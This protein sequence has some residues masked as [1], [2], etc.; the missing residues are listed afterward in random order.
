MIYRMCWNSRGWRMPTHTSGDGGYPR[1]MGFG[2]EEWNFQTEDAVDGFIFGYLYYRPSAKVVME[3]RG[4]FRIGFWSMHPDTRARLLVGVYNDAT[5]VKD[6]DL[7]RVDNVFGDK[8]AYKRRAEELSSVVP[9]MS[10]DDALEKIQNSVRSGLLNFK[11]RV[12]DLHIPPEPVPID[13][14]VRNRGI[15]EHFTTPTFVAELN[16]PGTRRR[17]AAGSASVLAEDAYYRENPQSLKRIIRRHNTLSNKFALWLERS[18]FSE[19]ARQRDYV[20][21]TFEKDAARYRAELKTC[22][23]VG[24]TKAIREALGQLLEYNLYPGKDRAADHWA[25]IIDERPTRHDIEY[26]LVLRRQLN[27]PLCLGWKERDGFVFPDGLGL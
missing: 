22:Y 14:V 21:V 13:T 19:V 10:F 20:D 6:D 2:M 15:G 11:C 17:A 7:V 4:R 12:E 9:S 5:L 26:L 16:L 8:G 3:S 1:D 18:G 23:G 25:I 24:S 27:L